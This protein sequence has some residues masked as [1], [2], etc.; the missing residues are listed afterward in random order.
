M[1]LG[2]NFD[3]SKASLAA[4]LVDI[5]ESRSFEIDPKL[6]P[7]L[8]WEIPLIQTGTSVLFAFASDKRSID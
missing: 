3:C 2:V 1:C 5:M 7:W 6:A 8:F 4:I